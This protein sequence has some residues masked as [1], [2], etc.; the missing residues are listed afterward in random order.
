VEAILGKPAVVIW[1]ALV[2][3]GFTCACAGS[4]ASN[5]G[6]PPRSAQSK[7]AGAGSTNTGAMNTGAMNTG[8]MNTA[9]A[10]TG[11]TS[12]GHGGSGGGSAGTSDGM[13]PGDGGK[14]NGGASNSG[15]RGSAVRDAAVDARTPDGDSSPESSAGGAPDTRM[16][17]REDSD[18]INAGLCDAVIGRCVQCMHDGDCATTGGDCVNGTCTAGTTCQSSLQCAGRADGKTICNTQAI[19]GPFCAECTKDADCGAG[20]T[21]ATLAPRSVF[22]VQKC[23]PRC[24][25]DNQCTPLGKVC[26]A[27]HFCTD[28]RTSADCP[29]SDY[30]ANPPTSTGGAC[31]HHSCIPNMERCNDGK[32]IF[33]CKSDGSAMEFGITCSTSCVNTQDSAMCL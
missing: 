30:C 27:G 4:D 13:A 19:N 32:N 22:G 31:L 28:C 8:A 15:G 7:D 24:S 1:A 9:G 14:L 29:A 11:G 5:G 2:G 33:T 20:K 21:C 10:S 12:G 23:L 6:G 26:G 3:F 25:S 18:C 17:C 16:P